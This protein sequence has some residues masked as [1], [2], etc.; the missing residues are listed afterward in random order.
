VFAEAGRGLAAAHDAGVVH[1]DFKPANV[2]IDGDRRVRVTD[3][4]LAAVEGAPQ[5]AAG[6]GSP[7]PPD[8]GIAGAITD[9]GAVLGTPAYMSP[10]ARAGEGDERSDQYSF[11]VAL[12]EALAGERPVD[13]EIPA[14][15]PIGSR[16]RPVIRRGL[17]ADRDERFESMAAMVDALERANRPRGRGTLAI[18]G[19]AATAAVAAALAIAGRPDDRACD[20]AAKLERIWDAG[21]RDAARRAFDATELSYAPDLF[22]LA[23]RNL[24]AYRDQW[25]GAYRAAC[26]ATHVRKEQSAA[27]L[28]LRMECLDGE[29]GRFESAADLL[30]AATPAIVGQAVSITALSD[31]LARCANAPLLRAETPRPIGADDEIERIAAEYRATNAMMI[32][33]DYKAA[34]DALTRLVAR[35]GRVGYARMEAELY[36]ELGLA[37]SRT[38]D[39]AAAEESLYRA[40]EAAERAGSPDIKS[41]A[42]TIL[43]GMVGFTEGRHGEALVLARVAEAAT[44][45]LDDPLRMAQLI[46]N[47]G[48]IHFGRGEMDRAGADFQRALDLTVEALGPGDYR[49]GKGL[50]NV[51]IVA[52]ERGRLEEAIDSYGRALEIY[53]D[54]LGPGHPEVALALANRAIAYANSD[55]TG[56]AVAD[57]ERALEIRLAVF[58]PEHRAI[59]NTH[60]VLGEVRHEAGE[61]AAA[62]EHYDKARAIYARAMAADNPEMAALRSGIGRALLALERRAEAIA[63]LEAAL[64]IWDKHKMSTGKSAQTRFALARAIAESGGDRAAAIAAATR[65]RAEMAEHAPDNVE[66]IDRWLEAHR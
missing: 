23:A 20:P 63:E 35:A 58:G 50:N 57:L 21:E 32:E 39:P 28:D 25:A 44:R 31:G 11:A 4:G 13:G 22:A 8:E 54:T 27:T 1:R 34:L 62:L 61:P 56:D 47:G 6:S 41:T 3:F 30:G 38:G 14:G 60:A 29:L 12:C 5:I 65:A 26:E 42:M 49:V 18:V 7:P 16:L 55:R 40:I 10:E 48:A 24:D 64:E 36:K 46:G 33:G 52:A 59:G 37:Q 19:I 66:P 45:P 17:A 43:V 2:L 51:A 53:K 15:A 9:C